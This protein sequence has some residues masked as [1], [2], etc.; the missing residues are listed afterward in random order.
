MYLNEESLDMW[1]V[2]RY[3]YDDD[4]SIVISIESVWWLCTNDVPSFRCGM[5]I[6]YNG[7]KPIMAELVC[8][9]YRLTKCGN[10]TLCY[11]TSKQRNNLIISLHVRGKSLLELWITTFLPDW[12]P[13]WIFVRFIL[14][15]L[16]MCFKLWLV[17]VWF[18]HKSDKDSGWLSVRKKS[19]NPQF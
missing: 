2:S 3:V 10:P 18:W 17:L 13:P 12:Q 7:M 1:C 15:F 5:T 16:C 4:C 19:G 8:L 14:N 9:G 6:S 11:S